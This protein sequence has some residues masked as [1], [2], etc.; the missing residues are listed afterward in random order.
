MKGLAARLQSRP[1]L[2]RIA[3]N[4]GWLLADKLLKALVGLLMAAWLARHLG[5]AGFGHYSFVL[6]FVAMFGGFAT[7]GL[8]QIGV[9]ELVR[10]PAARAEILGTVLALLLCGALT[11][12]SLVAMAIGIVRS[13][14]SAARLAVVVCS[15]TLLFQC[16]AV[17]RYWFESQVAARHI[18]AAEAVA[19]LTGAAIKAALI[20][21]S[22]PVMAFFWA[23]LAESALMALALLLA[24]QRRQGDLRRWR[25]SLAR[26]RAMMASAW[27]IALSGAILMVQA[28][29][30]Q[31][32]LAELAG[33][34][35][36]GYYSVAL[37][38]AEGLVFFSLILQS[39]LYPV[40][41]QA[42]KVAWDEFHARLMSFYR[43]SVL[44]ALAVCLPLALL[45]P[46]LVVLLF[47]AAYE[48][49]GPL[50]AWMAGRVLLAF[51][52]VARSVFLL[53]ENRQAWAT[54]TLAV[55]TLLNVML[56]WIWIPSHQATGAVWASLVSFTVT[57]FVLDLLR[58]ATRRNVLDMGRAALTCLRVRK[59]MG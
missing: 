53:I 25:T 32:M 45:A 52:G 20:L 3:A 44:A 54:V 17:A 31:F 26:A 56:N 21:G 41:V 43:A 40:L 48:P 51:L 14:D 23:A 55:G 49:A 28:R 1:L 57:I 39:T 50:L 27:P 12:M 29:V 59:V 33:E 7:L 9:R 2:Q 22:A 46:W 37:R 6:A 42:R 58:A 24:Y 35:E 16:S 47:G 8:P 13:H 4:V 38:V 15:G 34:R 30:D 10:E 19:L 5:P 36:L 11:A 18:V